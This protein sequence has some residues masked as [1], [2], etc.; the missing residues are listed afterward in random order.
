MLWHVTNTSLHILGSIHLTDE[1][2]LLS[3]KMTTAVDRAEVLAFEANLDAPPDPLI[4]RYKRGIRLS[5][6]IAEDLFRET[7]SLWDQ[8][9]FD[10][11][12]LESLQP[13]L[14]ATRLTNALAQQHGLKYDDGID[15]KIFNQGKRLRKK[16]FFLESVNVFSN[17]MSQSPLIEQERYLALIVREPKE[18]MQRIR[19]MVAAWKAQRPDDLTPIVERELK[20]LPSI[21]AT[22]VDGRN[23]NWL[24]QLLRLVRSGK[25]TVVIVGALHMIGPGNLSDLLLDHGFSC[26]RCT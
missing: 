4:G 2:L 12:E 11:D 18:E 22:G 15:R 7:V 1:P 24:P 26:V 14:A 5:N 10:R 21:F 20:L 23:R 25:D 9:Q 13:W 17:I 3:E 8:F 16:H 6:S 19:Q